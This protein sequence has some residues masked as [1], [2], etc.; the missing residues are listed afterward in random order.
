MKAWQIGAIL[1]LAAVCWVGAG[2]LL[3]AVYLVIVGLKG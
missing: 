3:Y 1:T 2:F